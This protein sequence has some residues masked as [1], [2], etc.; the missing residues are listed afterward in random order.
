MVGDEA[1]FAER[2]ELILTNRHL[3]DGHALE[4]RDALMSF[5]VGRSHLEPLILVKIMHGLGNA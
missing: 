3:F 1:A 4:S 2:D 5:D